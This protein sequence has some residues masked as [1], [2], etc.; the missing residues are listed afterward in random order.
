MITILGETNSILNQYIAEIRDHKIQKDS[1]RFRK[2]MERISGIFAYEISKKLKYVSKSIET[3]LGISELAVLKET[4]VL[5][6][7]LRAGLPMHQGFLDCFDKAEN[8]FISVHR[9]HHNDGSFSI[10]LE[11]ISCPNIEKK[12]VIIIDPMIATGSSMEMA[13]NAILEKGT[14][15]HIHIASI[16]TSKDGLTYL[17]KHISMKNTTIWLGA[18]DDEL[19]VKSLIVPGLGDAGNLAYGNK[20]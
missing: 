18:V 14:P 15:E 10:T 13:Y 12:V 5:A 17:Q 11:Y 6:T 4:P 19:T 8:A 9:K 20:Q 16:I 2:N 3:P 1:L 7:V